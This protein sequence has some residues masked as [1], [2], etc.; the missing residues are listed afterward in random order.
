MD[1]VPLTI[2]GYLDSEAGP[3]PG[4]TTG[5]TAVFRIVHSPSAEL[6]DELVLP[7]AAADPRIVHAL[8]NDLEPGDLLRL[9][10][11]LTLPH[12]TTGMQLHVDTLDVLATVPLRT[13]G[14]AGPEA[15]HLTFDRYGAYAAV[16]RSDT[17]AVQLWTEA[18]AWIG[19]ATD[20]AAIGSLIDSYE[21]T[22]RKP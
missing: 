13:T 22:T 9:S 10:G 5:V 17:S 3:A 4:D 15:P 7:C 8:L 1:A 2:D 12:S 20:P 16:S 19:T 21:N 11:T 6:E 18:G 14:Q